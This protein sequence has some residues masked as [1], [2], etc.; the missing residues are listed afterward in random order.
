MDE[1]AVVSAQRLEV[2]ASE[3][4]VIV[5]RAAWDMEGGG[6]GITGDE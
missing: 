2:G 4:R 6:I 1:V 3:F 5:V